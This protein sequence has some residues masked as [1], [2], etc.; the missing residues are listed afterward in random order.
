MYVKIELWLKYQTLWSVTTL[1]SGISATCMDMMYH[2]PS[3]AFPHLQL[4]C[5]IPPHFVGAL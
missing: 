5:L 4:C 1:G 3:I 2:L